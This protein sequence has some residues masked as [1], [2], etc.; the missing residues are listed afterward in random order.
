MQKSNHSIELLVVIICNLYI[1]NA[2]LLPFVRFISAPL[3][4]DFIVKPY[5]TVVSYFFIIVMCLYFL[6]LLKVVRLS[7]IGKGLFIFTSF[8]IT[9][10]TMADKVDFFWDL[11]V[12]RSYGDEPNI[13]FFLVWNLT[14]GLRLGCWFFF[15]YWFF[16]VRTRVANN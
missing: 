16:F 13:T 3:P 5:S 11:F 15:S 10:A 12:I 9:G 14:E 6:T 2:W 8:V 4:D 7:L 1:G